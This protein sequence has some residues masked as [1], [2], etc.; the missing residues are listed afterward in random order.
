MYRSD[1]P[2]EFLDLL[3][4]LHGIVTTSYDETPERLGEIYRVETTSNPKEQLELIGDLGLFQERPE[5]TPYPTD[6]YEPTYYMTF[7]MVEYALAM[8]ISQVAMEDDKLRVFEDRSR[9]F[10]QSAK[11]TREIHA[12]T[13]FNTGFTSYTTADGQYLFDS[14]HPIAAGTDS[15]VGTLDVDV[16]PLQ[17]AITA[18]KQ[19]LTHRGHFIGA[20]P[21]K[22]LGPVDLAFTFR[23]LLGSTLR[24]DTSD[25]A[26]NAFRDENLDWATWHYLTD[27][28]AWFLLG[29]KMNMRG[30]WFDRVALTSR[31][32]RDIYTDDFLFKWRMRYDYG[33][34]D[35]RYTWG[36]PGA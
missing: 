9:L 28:D 12:A 26:V 21:A 30:Y 10:G 23:E 5:G 6:G 25:N 36:S 3:P 7:E 35:W 2:H 4:Y 20:V 19:Q 29:A 8:V 15:N 11:I 16:A 14:D 22:L 27:D 1:F 13:P 18:F 32:D 34:L 33:W 24:P 17:S 31:P